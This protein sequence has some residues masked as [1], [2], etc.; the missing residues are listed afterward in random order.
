MYFLEEFSEEAPV[1]GVMVAGVVWLLVVV[2]LGMVV[3]GMGLLEQPVFVAVLVGMISQMVLFGDL[4]V[5]DFSWFQSF[6]GSLL[7]SC[8][9]INEM[10]NRFLKSFE[11]LGKVWEHELKSINILIL[12]VLISFLDLSVEGM[13]LDVL[14]LDRLVPLVVEA[15][16]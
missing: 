1:G 12:I 10:L 15:V 6:D 2:L 7:K 16:D 8:N 9:F 13:L 11:N 3:L 5:V 4:L 14:S